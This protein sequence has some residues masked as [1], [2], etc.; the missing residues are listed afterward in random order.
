M[1]GGPIRVTGDGTP[2][3]SYLYA[4]D[5]AI[6]L[7]TILIKGAPGRAYNVGSARELSIADAARLVAS[8]VNAHAIVEREPDGT[9]SP[10][11]YVPDTRRAEEELGLRERIDLRESVSRTLAWHRR[12]EEMRMDRR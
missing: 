8:S 11:R 9:R 1:R 12:P 2:R 6:W 4:A 5:M 7:W 10:E 3:R